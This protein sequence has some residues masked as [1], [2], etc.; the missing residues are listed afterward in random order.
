MKKSEILYLSAIYFIVLLLILLNTLPRPVK[1]PVYKYI[2]TDAYVG[3][4]YA[5]DQYFIRYIVNQS[6]KVEMVEFMASSA[7]ECAV[8]RGFVGE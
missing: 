4:E 8:I 6:G 3:G 7:E 5:T 2:R 1:P